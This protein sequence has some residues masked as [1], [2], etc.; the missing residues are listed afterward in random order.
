MIEAPPRRANLSIVGATATGKTALAVGLARAR[1]DCELFSIDAIG[2]YRGLDIGSAKPDRAERAGLFWHLIDL[3]EP[4]EESSLAVFQRAA[5]D[6]LAGVEARSRSA[7]LVG[8]TGLYYRAVVDGLQLPG[9]YPEVAAELEAMAD[10]HGGVGRLHAR[11]AELDPLAASRM[12]PTNRRRIVRAL[13]VTLGS[14]RAFS[15][16]GPGLTS[17][18]RVP[19]VVV[20]LS[21]GREELALRIDARLQA[22]LSAGFLD[23][24]K[25]LAAQPNG[26]SRTAGQALGYRELLAHLAGELSLEEALSLVR[27]RTKRFA[28]RQESW[29]RRDPRVTWFEADRPDLQDAVLAHWSAHVPRGGPAVSD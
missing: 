16:Y 19:I 28:R 1:G 15:A 9:R 10:T 13:E 8:G 23:E 6:G 11:L 14:G 3:L 24:V 7:I 12:E 29:F 22:Q 25:T 2:V 4:S 18:P 21:L 20:G 27:S 5:L 17:Y 26:L